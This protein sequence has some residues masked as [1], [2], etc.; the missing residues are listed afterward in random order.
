MVFE[1]GLKKY[2]N[3]YVIGLTNSMVLGFFCTSVFSL[4]RVLFELIVL[5]S[6]L[7]YYTV[8]KR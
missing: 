7:L 1:I 8:Y 4:T 6:P 3:H 5:Q 2:Y